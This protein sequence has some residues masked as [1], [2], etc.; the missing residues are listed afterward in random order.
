MAGI[1]DC[2]L[3][4]KSNVTSCREDRFM[5]KVGD[6]HLFE[7]VNLNIDYVNKTLNFSLWQ[8][9]KEGQSILNIDK[10]LD[11]Y[12]TSPLQNICLDVL[13]GS[14]NVIYTDMFY[15]TDIK[16]HTSGLTYGSTAPMP[17]KDNLHL[18]YERRTRDY[19]EAPREKDYAQG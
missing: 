1:S 15:S 10:V 19:A 12:R 7:V 8:I 13:D 18:S 3:G 2:D 9:L 4:E 11:M 17:I 14:G 16:G 5:L 6:H